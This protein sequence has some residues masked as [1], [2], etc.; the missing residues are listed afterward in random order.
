M[1]PPAAVNTLPQDN[2]VG[3]PI[4]RK[5]DEALL[6]GCARFIDDLAPVPGLKHAAVLRSPHAHA[7]LHRIDTSRA[8]ALAGVV[9][10]V[11]GTD[12]ASLVGPIPSVVKAA[13]AYFPFAIDKVRYVGEP[14]TVVVADSRYIAEDAL[15]LIAVDYEPLP[16]VVDLEA[17]R[18]DGAPVLHEKTGSN[19]ISRRSFSYG[20]PDRAFAAAD[21]VFDLTY[22]YPRSAAM[23][24]ETFG[25]VAHFEAAPD[26]F[27]VWSNFQGPFVLHPLMASAL[28]V[29]GTRLRLITP[30]F[31][32]GSFGIKQ[33]VFSYIVLLA[34]VSRK[35]GRPVKWIEDRAEHLAASSAASAR[36]GSVSAAFA[37]DG[38]LTGLRFRNVADMGA[39]I[40]PP[41]PASLY[42]MHSAA[43]GCYRVK[44]IAVDNELVVTNRTPV[45]LNRGYGGP[46]FY[47]ALERIMEIAARG[48]GIDAAE[49]RRRN[50][51]PREAFPYTCPAGSIL[52]AGDYAGAL[53]E[54]LR[55][56]GYDALLRRRDAARKAGRLFGIGM[57]TG[58][59]P[60]GSNMAYVG[61]AQTPEERGRSDSK[62]GANASA[63]VSIDPSGHVTLR[64]CSAPNGQGH[65]TVAAQIVADRL[66]LRPEDIDVVTEIDTLTSAWSIAS[67]NYSNRFA[68]I[69]VGAI[70][71]AADKAAHKLKILAAEVLEEPPDR[72][73][74]VEGYARVVGPSNRR[75]S[76]RKV[77]ARAHW[78]PA[79]L[80]PGMQPGL[81]EAVVLSPPTLTSPD[82]A[83]RV[84]SA[85]TYGFVADLAAVEIDRSTGAIRID[86][87]VS[88]HDVGRQLNPLIVEGQAHGGFVHGLGAALMEELAY[89]RQGQFLS[90]TFA[91]YLCPTAAEVPPII[92][93]HVETPSPMNALG[94]KGMGD[95]SSMLA[96]AAIAN[97][98]ADAL[99]R[100]D[101][102]LPLTL[103]RVWSLANGGPAR[104][105]PSPQPTP[106]RA[107]PGGLSGQG[108][109]IL[110]A[111]PAEVWRRLTDPQELATIVPGCRNLVQDGPDRYS[112]EI[113]LGVSVIR[114]LY[115]AQI[116]LHD[117]RE[118]QSVRLVGRATGALGH[119]SGEGEVKLVA[120]P[121]GGTRLTY[122]YGAEVGERSRP[123]V[124]ACWARSPSPSSG[125]F[126]ARWNGGPHGKLNIRCGAGW[127]FSL[128]Y[129]AEGR[130]IEA[131]AIR[132]LSPRDNRRG[133]K[134]AFRIA[135]GRRGVG[136]RNVA[137]AHAQSAAG[138]AARGDR[139]H[140]HTRAR[141]DR[142][143]RLN[144]GDGQ[145]THTGRRAR[146]SPDPA[147]TSASVSG[148][149]LARALPDPQPR[150]R[151]RLDRPRRSQRRNSAVPR[152][153]RRY[154]RVAL[155]PA[156]AA[157]TRARLLR[158]CPRNGPPARRTPDRGR[159]ATGARN[160]RTRIR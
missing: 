76:L 89:D 27:T 2:F 144:R 84:P 120:T 43:N 117:K 37:H 36:I 137:C 78:D 140:A 102:V 47:F 147:R 93:G 103:Q 56:A 100:D 19:V 39:Y 151:R 73:E 127:R 138:S 50:F 1:E 133:H 112:A 74:L 68:A 154:G 65:A 61:L 58:I 22:E 128:P 86:K 71:Q 152:R 10:I 114:G 16:A 109:V 116:E 106:E 6:S 91:D 113:M 75:L 155:A 143:A 95:G 79:G 97:A 80:P 53:D 156:G 20:D 26:R 32:G 59:E 64:L 94:A 142:P 28:K 8:A 101:L 11:S 35:V 77:A 25:V 129:C 4:T 5:E 141:C 81:H 49:L 46:Q 125:N 123:L 121:E 134:P 66:G 7:R 90:G 40:R 130:R 13:P 98:V 146:L 148:A 88:V 42:R 55:L 21:R 67:G 159:M 149:P 3:K 83:D 51:I 158:R 24:M 33:A 99:G 85:V 72:I 52:D 108:E 69:V 60:S 126:S 131:C 31:S 12:L 62:S 15:D 30:P 92:I 105:E 153:H 54:L 45:G 23:P 63:V 111:P 17:A 119:G 44:N 135:A 70:A 82:S 160:G 38:E 157:R 118:P 115:A 48:L 122:R 136:R 107:L 145:H 96:P 124:I 150:H 9:G 110:T 139:H 132:V 18:A 57:A 29:P 34:A 87:Y 104:I 14:V 41:E